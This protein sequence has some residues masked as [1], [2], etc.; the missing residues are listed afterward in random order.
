MSGLK[1][2]GTD[3]AIG[4]M[5]QDTVGTDGLVAVVFDDVRFAREFGEE[6]WEEGR[7]RDVNDVGAT[8][9]APQLQRGGG[10]DDAEW[11]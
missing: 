4:L 9:Q 2:T 5:D 8:N 3:R 7:A 10:A 6:H 11:K 1:M